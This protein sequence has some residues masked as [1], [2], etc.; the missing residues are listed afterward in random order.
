MK[1]FDIIRESE[2]LNEGGNT[3]AKRMFSEIAVLAAWAGNGKTPDFHTPAEKWLDPKKLKNPEAVIRNVNSELKR[4]WDID[5]KTDPKK[6]TYLPVDQ[7]YSKA[8]QN[9]QR[10]LSDMADQGF[11]IPKQFSW[12]GWEGGEKTS[13]Q[14]DIIFVD[15]PQ[16]AG[17][18]VKDDGGLG[19]ANLGAGEL[20][21][22]GK[23]DLFTNLA[24]PEML[25]LKTRVMKDLQAE[26]KRAGQYEVS[27]GKYVMSWHPEA[28]KFQ[29]QTAGEKPIAGTP[30]QLL[31]PEFLSTTKQWHRT[32][33][34]YFVD[35][36]SKYTAETKA[37]VVAI[38]DI[39]E[40]AIEQKI[41]PNATK[42]AKL[43]GFG[44][45][46][47]YY[48]LTAKG[49]DFIAYVPDLNTADDIEVIGIV[50]SGVFDTGIKYI[51]KLRRP[52][53]SGFATVEAKIRYDLGAFSRNAV[54]KITN[55]K[56]KEHLYWRPL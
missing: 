45:R 55:L 34:K 11:T 27:G 5:N 43:G 8:V 50:P 29:I 17:I 39:I 4:A 51:I 2:I 56:G 32:L 46:P 1:I 49:N 36:Q 41:L 23:G 48:Q 30:Q 10:I 40:K 35:N 19:V 52:G 28:N 22:E 53:A 14:S 54:F 42:L 9:K 25:A 33:G 18:S 12:V 44:S 26:V 15:S 6:K 47:Y 16:V 3:D 13:S 21:F 38:S 31:S 7:Y 37:I 24:G 20:E